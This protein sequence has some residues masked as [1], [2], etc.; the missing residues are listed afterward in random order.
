VKVTIG[1]RAHEITADDVLTKTFRR[2]PDPVEPGTWY[3][4]IRRKRVPA[5]WAVRRTLDIPGQSFQTKQAI[6]ILSRLGFTTGQ[7]D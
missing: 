2:E 3:A 4:V 5:K 6:S 1:G 7:Q